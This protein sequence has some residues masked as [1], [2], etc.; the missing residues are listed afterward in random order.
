MDLEQ[1]IPTDQ[2]GRLLE[3]GHAV[4]QATTIRD[5]VRV[6]S[7]VA[8]P[9]L[10]ASNATALLLDEARSRLVVHHGPAATTGAVHVVD[11]SDPTPA[12]RVART[13]EPDFIECVE[14]LTTRYPQ[15]SQQRGVVTWAALA[16]LPL[17]DGRELFGVIVYRWNEPVSFTPERRA[18][19]TEITELLGLALARAEHHDRLLAYARRLRESNRDLDSFA[20]AVAHDLRQPLRQLSSYVDVL[21]EHLGVDDFDADAHHYASRIRAAVSRA[22]Q[23]IVALLDYASAGGKALGDVE[24][25]LDRLVREVIDGLRLQLDEAGATVQLRP[26]ADR[27]G[28]P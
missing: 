22:D 27:A 18:L 15:F 10:G 28:R 11:L 2:R 21:F 3:L 5:V 25:A 12:A 1:A 4:A 14:E 23:L 13:S 26:A 8:G 16:V 17:M 7:E 6:V 24:V 9:L 20:A 19:L